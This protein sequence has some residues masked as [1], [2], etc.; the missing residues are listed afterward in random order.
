MLQVWIDILP[1]AAMRTNSF[2]CLLLV[3]FFLLVQGCGTTSSPSWQERNAKLVD[4]GNGVCRQESGLMWQVARTRNLSSIEEARQHVE[5]LTLAGYSDWR[6]PLKRELF[7]LCWIF[8]L[9]LAGDC[10]IKQEGSYWFQNG[11]GQAGNWEAYP[12]CGGSD[13]VFMKGKKGRV[14]AVRP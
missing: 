11:T 2:T 9:K 3:F 1:E 14:R 10:P 13:Y 4:T 5:G 12:M 7:E 6:L 8:D